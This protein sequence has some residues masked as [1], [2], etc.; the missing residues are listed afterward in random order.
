MNGRKAHPFALLLLLAAITLASCS[1]PF[2]GGNNN[3]GGAANVSFTLVAD[4]LP[5]N[6]SILSFKV[7]I[8]GIQLTPTAGPAITLTPAKPIVDLMRLQSDSAFLGT[9]TKVPAGTYT[10]KVSLAAPASGST[11]TFFNDTASSITAGSMTCVSGSVCTATLTANG[12]P[13]IASFTLTVT[14]SSNQGVGLDFN[15]KNAISLSGGALTVNFNPTSP[16]L[17]AFTL[18]RQNANLASGQLDLIEDFT[19]VVSL[20]GNNLTVTSPTRG[21]LTALISGATVFDQS[22]APSTLCANPPSNCAAANQIASIDAFLNADGTLSLKEFEPLTATQQDLVEGIVYLMSGATQFAMVVSDKM[23][24]ASGSLIGGLNTGDLLTVNISSSVSPFFVDTKGLAVSSTGL[25]EG[26]TN[27]TVMHQGQAIAVHVSAF[28]AASGTTIASATVD[29]VTLR[30]SRLI[31]SLN[32]SSTT[33]VNVTAV[34]SYFGITSA[35]IFPTQVFTGTLGA[36][37]VTNLDGI[38]DA[39]SLNSTLPVGVRVLY[40][41]NPTHTA[42]FPFLA[43]KIRQH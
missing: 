14:S 18:P 9:L 36:D 23:Q 3:H 38:T 17:T 26:A 33:T 13:T 15:L 43:A 7:S 42:Q 20:S 34:P 40:L 6:P 11:I 10:V 35:S 1:G 32:S 16:L 8:N 29:A 12:T 41:D 39:G 27:T 37:G 25:F 5:A 2:S 28:T 30:W 21:A 19:G 24:A 22:P 31:A 4:T